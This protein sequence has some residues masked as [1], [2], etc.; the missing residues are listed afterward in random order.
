MKRIVIGTAG[1]I[2]HGKT[3]LIK[4]LTGIDCDRLKVEKERGITTE[5][6]FAYYKGSDDILLG[7]VDVPGHEKFVRH[8]VSGAWGIDMVLLV[9]AADEGVMPQTREHVDI[10][11]LLGLKKAVVAI[12]KID[13]VDRDMLELVIED[14]KE[15]L[16]GRAFEEAPI[17]PVSSLTG[18][19]L[20]L[21]KE[22][23]MTVAKSARE[24]SRDGIFRLPVDRVFSVKGY[25]TVVTGTCIS[26]KIKIGE[27]VEI[28]P[29]QK[30][31]K[32]RS[33]QAYYE[34][35]EEAG[36]G[37]RIALNLQ[38]ID[39][40]N[41]ERGITIGN[42]GRLLP[43]QRI[44]VAFK[45]IDLP[46]KPIKNDTVLRFH[47]ATTQ[48][49]ARLI[50][51]EKDEI[52]PGEE[53]FCQFVFSEPV[54]AM[55][56][57]SFI[58][59]GSYL[60]SQT[61][62]GGVVLNITPKKHKRKQPELRKIYENL[63]N[64]SYDEKIEFFIKE[65]GY[66][67]ISV[68]EL[69]TISGIKTGEFNESVSRLVGE[70]RVIKVSNQLM[71]SEYLL[72]TRAMVVSLLKEFH[73]RNPLKI[74]MPKEELRQRLPRI[75]EQFFSFIL[76]SLTSEGLV[77][78]EKDRVRLASAKPK[79][80]DVE[81][82]EE[83][84]MRKL[85]EFDLNAPSFAELREGFDYPDNMLKDFMEKLS[86]EGKVVKL[87]GDMYVHPSSLRKF[88]E[89]VVSFLKQKGEA[90]PSEIKSVFNISRK[91]LIPLLEYLDEIKVTIRKGD[92]RVL[93]DINP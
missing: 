5:L 52:N 41:L 82:L 11:E 45:L 30:Y 74:G 92:K 59:R 27:Q 18:E 68:G 12:T 93:R 80:L 49:E 19:N 31:A 13:I 70:N 55:P 26:G 14:V 89:G 58:V 25:G 50:V 40:E 84:I 91:Y 83:R 53:L 65:R 87:K 22:K 64:G 67:G 76:D 43:T 36:A 46:I 2:D 6:G 9:V 16:K 33:I 85:F 37:E 8:M 77:E 71:H 63:R 23:I 17:V 44:D 72:N 32:V 20:G 79:D 69:E 29:L 73:E 57:D 7:I 86:Y 4:A 56:G 75:K 48:R 15:F 78:T 28:Y 1:H 24:R 61:I 47:I 90:S 34:E 51:L 60:P 54:V 42:P 38:G 35:R 21:L 3:A 39:R 62:G 81:S 88:K 66:E 10:C